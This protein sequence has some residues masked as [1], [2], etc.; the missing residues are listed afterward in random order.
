[1]EQS[2]VDKKPPPPRLPGQFWKPGWLAEMNNKWL[3]RYKCQPIF[4]NSV[5]LHEIL[6][7]PRGPSRTKGM[8][9]ARKL[10]PMI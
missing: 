10:S 7:I 2:Y 3:S 9:S 4:L 5:D 8:L 6:T 1:M